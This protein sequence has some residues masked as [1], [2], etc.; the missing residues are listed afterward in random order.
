M[1]NTLKNITNTYRQARKGNTELVVIEGVHA[2]KHAL[3]FGAEFIHIAMTDSSEALRVLKEFG[4]EDEVAYVNDAVEIIKD[5]IWESLSPIP[6]TTGIIALAKKPP[7]TA[8][9]I[10]D[11]I[12]FIE[13]PTSL[14]NVGAIIRTVAAAG[15]RTFAMSGRHNPWHA[16]CVNTARGLNFALDYVNLITNEE[17]VRL[18]NNGGYTIYAMDTHTDIYLSDIK[19]NTEKKIFL[20]GTER[21]G[22]SKS[23]CDASEKVVKLPMRNGVSSLNLASSVTATLFCLPSGI[24]K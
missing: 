5:D 15:V 14:F 3:R 6:H 19:N 24:T 9:F 4:E 22:L 8:G 11:T 23:L 10:G 7:N 1:Q 13:D 16:D 17:M 21:Y 20:F 12:V 2:V 18:A